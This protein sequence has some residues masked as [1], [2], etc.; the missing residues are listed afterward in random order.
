MKKLLILAALASVLDITV[1]AQGGLRY[2]IQV[3]EF[4]NRSGWSGQW[5]LGDAWG[6][7][8]TDKLQQSGKYIVISEQDMR[9]A[10][11]EEQ[12]FA[13][14]GRTAGGSKSPQTGQ[15]TPAQVILKGVITSFDEG[16]GGGGGGIG[17]KGIRVG[18]GKT[19]SLITG[20]V[21]AVDTT[22]GAV[23]ASQNFE[24]KVTA[25]RLNVGVYKNGFAGNLGGFKKTAVGKVM[26]QAC[27]QI[28]TFLD[29]QI[30]G[31]PWSGT[32]IRGGEDNIIINRGSREGVSNGLVLRCGTA[33]EIRD[34]DT[35][36]LLDRD[37]IETAKLEV[38]RVKEKLCYAKLITG[39]APKKGDRVY[40]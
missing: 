23:M 21:Y 39:K 11:M 7:V 29:A 37:F 5:R 14:S 8:L 26:D 6:A 25:Q 31:V 9:M 13:T 2:T 24:A 36:E 16:T 22:T 10:S 28:V 20:T 40:N 15:M 38:T 35:G 34:P 4:D 3:R 1:M 33:E 27:A 19:T 17:Y 32:I 18:G 12:D 30:A